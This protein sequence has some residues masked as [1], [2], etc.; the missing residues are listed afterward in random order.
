MKTIR[1]LLCTL[2][3]IFSSIT[4]HAVVAHDTWWGRFKKSVTSLWSSEDALRKSDSFEKAQPEIKQAAENQ[5]GNFGLDDEAM[6]KGEYANKYLLIGLFSG[7]SSWNK[8]QLYETTIDIIQN[9]EA[10]K[11]YYNS[12]DFKKYY[13]SLKPDLDEDEKQD[14]IKNKILKTAGLIN[15]F[16]ENLHYPISFQDRN[17][18]CDLTVNPNRRATT[19]EKKVLKRIRLKLE[20]EF[21]QRDVTQEASLPLFTEAVRDTISVGGAALSNKMIDSDIVSPFADTIGLVVSKQVMADNFPKIKRYKLKAREVGTSFLTDACYA[22]T[23]FTFDEAC[24]DAFGTTCKCPWNK[25]NGFFHRFVGTAVELV[26]RQ[27]VKAAISNYLIKPL[28]STIFGEPAHKKKK[29]GN[30][31]KAKIALRNMQK[32]REHEEEFSDV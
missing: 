14:L 7:L 13:H 4:T 25:N 31:A 32:Q 12:N 23:K 19:E 18:I 21:E 20:K 29:I 1:S 9:F 11:S 30:L 17:C 8:T 15:N 16:L 6:T 3:I 27:V 2:L 28:V 22:V 24:K 10:D 5:A 26:A